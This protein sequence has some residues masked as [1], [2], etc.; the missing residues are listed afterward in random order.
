MST[1]TRPAGDDAAPAGRGAGRYLLEVVSELE[2]RNLLVDGAILHGE[3]G[4]VVLFD[5]PA[6]PTLSPAAGPSRI[7]VSA[8]WNARLGWSVCTACVG[9]PALARRTS[10]AAGPTPPAGE[11]ADFVV[12]AADDGVV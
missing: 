4:A 10:L 8:S 12:R 2:R 7:L 11:V 5:S 9:G 1:V 6:L 3:E